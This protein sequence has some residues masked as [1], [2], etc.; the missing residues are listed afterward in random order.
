MIGAE[1]QRRHQLH[2]DDLGAPHEDRS[3]RGDWTRS[4]SDW[5]RVESDYCLEY[6]AFRCWYYRIYGRD[7]VVQMGSLNIGLNM[8]PPWLCRAGRYPR[9]LRILQQGGT[10]DNFEHQELSEIISRAFYVEASHGHAVGC[11]HV[12]SHLCVTR[13]GVTPLS[14]YIAP[15]I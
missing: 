11:F 13:A 5:E 1:A 6:H 14:V 10:V 4:G 8:F 7:E 9:V 3:G 12:I 15:N 2:W